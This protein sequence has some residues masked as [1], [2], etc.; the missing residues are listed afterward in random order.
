MKNMAKPR[1]IKYLKNKLKETGNAILAEASPYDNIYGIGL[2]P[3]DKNV[4]D[5]ESKL[6]PFISNDV[7]SNNLSPG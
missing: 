2:G 5:D 7:F 6:L 4:Q 1:D 3:K